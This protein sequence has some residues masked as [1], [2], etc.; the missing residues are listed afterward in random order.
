[1]AKDS[2]C[3]ITHYLLIVLAHGGA[4]R[5]TV[6]GSPALAPMLLPKAVKTVPTARCAAVLD[7][8]TPFP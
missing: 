1:M 6:L 5:A 8:G 4:H 7:L 2:H 3:G